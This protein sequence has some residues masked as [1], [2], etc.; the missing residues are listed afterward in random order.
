MRDT[1][2]IDRILEVTFFPPTNTRGARWRV[3]GGFL[4]KTHWVEYQH[5]V[6][7][8]IRPAVA[9]EDAARREGFNYVAYLWEELPC[10]VY[11]VAVMPLKQNEDN[12]GGVL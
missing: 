9:A 10:G 3:R 6:C 12:D 8:S 2:V 1:S 5:D 11:A 7:S 4:R